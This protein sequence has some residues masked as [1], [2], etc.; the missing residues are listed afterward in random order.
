MMASHFTKRLAAPSALLLTALLATPA[1]AAAPT[2][3]ATFLQDVVRTDSTDVEIGQLALKNSSSSGV[4]KL[5]QMLIDDHAA[6]GLEA[7]RLAN[8]LQVSLPVNETVD[9]TATYQALSRLSGTAFDRAF[10]DAVIQN[11][12]AAITDYEQQAASGDGEVAAFAEE[13][14]PVLQSQLSMAR[15]L[16]SRLG[17]HNTP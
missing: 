14:L 1:F 12:Q 9:Q 11:K 3:D 5:G 4:K 16:K 15:M 17:Q 6:R 8:T 7:T 13:T 2:S 10:I